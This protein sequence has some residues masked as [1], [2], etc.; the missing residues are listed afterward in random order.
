MRH[1]HVAGT[2]V[3]S[4]LGMAIAAP[5]AMAQV[6]AGIPQP[7]NRNVIVQMFNWRFIDIT[8]AISTLSTP[9]T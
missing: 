3:G 9:E 1:L 8:N 2:V 4:L 6:A 7:D 5:I